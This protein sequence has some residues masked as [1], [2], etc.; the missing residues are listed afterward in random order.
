MKYITR[1]KWT[2]VSRPDDPEAFDKARAY[3][4]ELY[5]SRRVNGP[6]RTSASH[7]FDGELTRV[8]KNARLDGYYEYECVYKEGP[9]DK[10]LMEAHDGDYLRDLY[11]KECWKMFLMELTWRDE[12]PKAMSHHHLGL[13]RGSLHHQNLKREFA[14]ENS[15]VHSSLVERTTRAHE[16]SGTL[17]N[18]RGRGYLTL[19][20]YDDALREFTD[21]VKRHE[22]SSIFVYNQGLAYLYLWRYD[23][24]IQ[25]FQTAIKL[26][27]KDLSGISKAHYLRGLQKKTSDVLGA[28]ED[29]KMALSLKKEEDYTE[30]R[31]ELVQAQLLVRDKKGGPIRE[32]A[33]ARAGFYRE[34]SRRLVI[35]SDPKKVESVRPSETLAMSGKRSTTVRP[36][37]RAGLFRVVARTDDSVRVAPRLHLM[38]QGVGKI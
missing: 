26:G 18:E 28:I 33:I 20:R 10:A 21:A 3:G 1:V 38:V 5:C 2:S 24:A 8:R 12:L 22:K 4:I 37:V 6:L 31:V 35:A 32:G 23:E 17:A 27:N 7:P 29:F 15:L 30:A 14:S 9:E 11:Y 36:S 34:S 25:C 16:A 19:A 13:D